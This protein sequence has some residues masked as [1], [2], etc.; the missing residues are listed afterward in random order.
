MKKDFKLKVLLVVLA[1]MFLIS[2]CSSSDT[3]MNGPD[4]PLNTN[5]ENN[6]EVNDPFDNN[7]NDP[8]NDNE[9]NENE[10]F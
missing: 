6:L 3:D 4:N 9:N 1:S 8:L 5:D 7:E 10:D 2:A